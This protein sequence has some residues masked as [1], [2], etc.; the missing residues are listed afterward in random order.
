ML[1]QNDSSG[2][3]VRQIAQF[4]RMT[5]ARI[6]DVS[7][8]EPQ[9]ER[10]AMVTERG[11][12]HLLEMPFSA[13]MWPPP[14]RRKVAR[15]SV[16]ETSEA[17]NSAVSIA[18]GAIGA[19]YQA[20]KPSVTRSRRSS[21]NTPAPGNTLR[22][23]AA[24]GDRAIAATISHSLGKTGNAINQL[25]HTGENRVSLPPG[26][27]IPSAACVTWLKGCKS[28]A[29]ATVG[30][31][32]VRTFPCSRSSAVAGKRIA[33]ANKY[34][35]VKMPLLPDDV[36][37]PVVH[38]IVDLGTPEE[39]FDLSDVEMEAGNTMTLKSQARA[40]APP[41]YGLDATIPHAEIESSAPYQPFH[42]D[43]RVA[44][45]Q[46]DQGGAAAELDL[47]SAMLA[48]ASLGDQ[49]SSRKRKKRSDRAAMDAWAFGQDIAAVKLDV[50]LSISPD[51]DEAGDD[52]AALPASAMERVMQYGQKE[53]IV[54]TT[55]RRRGVRQGDPDEDG[56]FEDDREVLDFVDQSLS[57]DAQHRE[58]G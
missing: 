4:S 20:A 40:A 41:L 10:L 53:Q 43:R 22:D 45:F 2:P 52:H 6:V 24:Q 19:A 9:G 29:L 12:V 33:R 28:Q 35:D 58:L 17:S 48:N 21:A 32:L 15:K 18:S 23:S 50:G 44:L 7:W 3:L 55:R 26:A 13:F 25:R 37:A 36:V 46:Y 1:P 39:Y 14:R 57:R 56:F 38:Q 47:V 5:V 31:G 49:P 42:T 16:A 51:D 34:R 54:V 11:T 8:T 30:G 27:A